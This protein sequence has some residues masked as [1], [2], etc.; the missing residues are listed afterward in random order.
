VSPSNAAYTVTIR[1]V[2]IS[3]AQA[4]GFS[5]GAVGKSGPGALVLDSVAIDGNAA[6]TG[7]ALFYNQGQ[8]TISNSAL[9]DNHS[10]FGGGAITA[11]QQS[12]G[13]N[14]TATVINSTI[15]GNS[16]D[17]LGGGVFIGD[18]GSI[19]IL[20]STVTRN[21]ADSDSDGSGSAGGVYNSSTGPFTVANSL[22]AENFVGDGS[23]DTQCGG[24]AFNSLGYNLRSASDSGCN[25][26]GNLGDFV[27][28]APL[29][30][31]APALNG[32]PT[33]NVAL[34]SGSP[35][36]D[37]GNPAIPGGPSPACPATDQR[38]FFRGGVAGRCDIGSYELNASPTP[39]GGGGGGTTTP[40]TTLVTPTFNLKAA[41]KKCKKKFPKGPKPKK[42]IKRAKRRAGL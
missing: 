12:E 15:D 34:L 8:T 40:P 11:Q 17:E 41:I 36:I 39:S 32:G 20:S 22:L 3:G 28:A 27:D 25:G 7:A 9:T 5:S 35:A 26:F 33:P 38:G 16:S 14:G 31:G 13:V 42:C 18:A 29:I 19:A 1:D 2:T 10:A 37:A 24:N 6:G 21:E 30:A 23:G 4:S